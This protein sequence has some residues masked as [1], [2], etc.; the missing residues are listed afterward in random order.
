MTPNSL[1]EQVQSLLMVD[2]EL[3]KAGSGWLLDQPWRSQVAQLAEASA[4]RA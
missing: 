4:T 1:W 2:L 3:S